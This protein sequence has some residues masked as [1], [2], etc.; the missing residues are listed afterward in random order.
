MRRMQLYLTEEQRRR[1]AQRAEDVGVSQAEV[2]RRILDAGL[3]I[4]AGARERVAAVD[5][6][7]GILAGHPDWPEWLGQVR[8]RPAAER[9]RDLGL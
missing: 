3:G 8:A 1:I 5:A 4:D 7:A 2:V 6:T 9:L